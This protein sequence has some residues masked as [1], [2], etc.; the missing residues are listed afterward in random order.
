MVNCIQANA[1]GRPTR[2]CLIC[3]EKGLLT[4]IALDEGMYGISIDGNCCLDHAALLILKYRGLHQRTCSSSHRLRKC[5]HHIVNPK[6][7][8]FNPIAMAP[9]LLGNWTMRGQRCREYQM[10]LTLS[11]HKRYAI[12]HAGF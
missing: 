4:S 12:A 8:V 11:H 3:R 10:A 7:H 1:W 9:H 2:D 6:R 5:P